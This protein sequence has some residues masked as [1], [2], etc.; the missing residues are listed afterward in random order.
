MAVALEKTHHEINTVLPR[1]RARGLWGRAIR[2]RNFGP[3]GGA[4]LAVNR[5]FGFRDRELSRGVA[6]RACL[7]TANSLALVV[8][9]EDASQHRASLRGDVR[10][11]AQCA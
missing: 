8:V 2:V 6:R 4:D 7:V 9:P 5:V 1:V 10:D 11:P 3:A